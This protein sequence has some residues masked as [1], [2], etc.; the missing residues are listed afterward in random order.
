[1]IEKLKSKRIPIIIISVVLIVAIVCTIYFIISNKK[2][3]SEETLKKYFEA[4]N[5]QDYE[6]MYEMISKQS[7]EKVSKEDF[8]DRN[9]KI[10]SS[11]DL[12]NIQITINSKEKQGSKVEKIDYNVDMTLASG[13]VS[14]EN[15]TSLQ[16]ESKQGFFIEWNSNMIF[17]NLN[18]TDKVKVKRDT[19]KRGEIQDRNGVALAMQGQISSVR[20]SSRKTW[21]K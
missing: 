1:M 20:N 19:A 9:K 11:I 16:K 21:G 12:E 14:F 7:K 13:K 4:I 8:I 15:K 6:A 5:N 10:Y 2:T 3:N 17:P 18:N